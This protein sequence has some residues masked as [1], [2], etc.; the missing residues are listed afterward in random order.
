MYRR[1]SHGYRSPHTT[2][3]RDACVIFLV[4][5]MSSDDRERSYKKR[6]KKSK[7]SKHDRKDK[8]ED[9]NQDS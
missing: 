8:D 5:P 6:S 4:I 3:G 2:R 9:K 7:D 1:M